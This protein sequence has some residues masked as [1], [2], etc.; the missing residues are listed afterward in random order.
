M[1]RDGWIVGQS[2]GTGKRFGMTRPYHGVPVKLQVPA[3]LKIVVYENAYLYDNGQTLNEYQLSSP[4]RWVEE[5][6]VDAEKVFFVDFARPLSGTSSYKVK[7]NENTG[8]F[9]S[10][11]GTTKDTSIRDIGALVATS[12]ALFKASA[13]EQDQGSPL[14]LADQ[15]VVEPRVVAERFFDINACDLDAQ[16]AAFIEEH[17]NCSHSCENAPG[18][19]R[20]ARSVGPTSCDCSVPK[21]YVRP[22]V[23]GKIPPDE[24]QE[25]PPEEDGPA[26]D[27]PS[28]AV[29]PVR[30]HDRLGFLVPG[31]M[32][33]QGWV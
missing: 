33:V 22:T 27:A 6:V 14:N 15:L 3:Y 31:D 11:S 7:I 18:D 19:G 28:P 17:V 4:D 26:E 16:V 9:T 23:A 24:K 32:R 20:C 5:T 10:V 25:D 8:Y 21:A 12:A 2:N 13:A 1:T 29:N 30:A